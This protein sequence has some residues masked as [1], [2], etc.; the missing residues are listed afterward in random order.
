MRQHGLP[1]KSVKIHLIAIFAVH[2]N[3]M[4]VMSKTRSL[5]QQLMMSAC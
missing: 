3:G 2:A 1:R 5:Q 4:R